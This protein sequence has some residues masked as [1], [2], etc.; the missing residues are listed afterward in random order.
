MTPAAAAARML[1]LLLRLLVLLIAG[2][3][4][5]HEEQ[6]LQRNSKHVG[7][8]WASGTGG[9]TETRKQDLTSMLSKE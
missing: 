9:C 2:L 1:V 5:L 8:E 7:C 6:G 3:C 4:Q